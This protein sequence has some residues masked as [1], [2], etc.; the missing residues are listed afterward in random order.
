MRWDEP[1]CFETKATTRRA[2]RSRPTFGGGAV[3]AGL[4]LT[5]GRG[6]TKKRAR[7]ALIYAPIKMPSLSLVIPCRNE[8]VRLPVTLRAVAAWLDARDYAVEVLIVV[9]KSTDNTAELAKTQEAADGRFRAICNP[10]A[11]GKGYAVKTGMLAATGD[12][13]FFMDVD[14]SVPLRFVDAFL[15]HFEKADVVFGSRRH[16]ESVIAVRQPLFRVVCGRAFNV[17]LRLCGATSFRDTQC[18]FKGYRRVAARAVFARLSV[19]GFGFDVEAMARAEA[20][21]LRIVERPV[22]WSDAPGT[23]VRALRQGTRAFV[24]AVFA[25]RRARDEAGGG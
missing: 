8:A 23:K 18:G 4:G 15:P 12:I 6:S 14:L 20:L 2:Q 21:G 13:V 1:P 5:L 22:E 11:R 10:V 9:E 3:R 24:E 7:A 16:P 19:D 17:A 25:A